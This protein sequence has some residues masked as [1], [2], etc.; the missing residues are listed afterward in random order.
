MA[1]EN[2]VPDFKVYYKSIT[3]K[4][5]C[6]RH[7]SRYT[8]LWKRIKDSDINTQKKKLPD[9]VKEHRNLPKA[10][11][12]VSSTNGT[13]GPCVYKHRRIKLDQ[14]L[15]PYIKLNSK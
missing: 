1:A 10:Q 8:S 5:A 14:Y 9:F 15:S 13:A 3:I 12:A 11:K 2:A 4:I 7:Q 6:Y